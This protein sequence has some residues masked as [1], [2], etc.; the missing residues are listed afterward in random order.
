MNIFCV[1]QNY[2]VQKGEQI[3]FAPVPVIFVKP[4]NALLPSGASF[5]CPNFA[6]VLYCGSELVLRIS[7][8]GKDV[9]EADAG[10]YYDSITIGINF[11]AI[12]KLD[13]LNGDASSW[14][15]A[16]AWKNSSIAGEW[17]P[18]TNFKN[19]K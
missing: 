7:K 15:K 2:F 9:N 3:D 10:K 13:A 19:K 5:S 1:E 18:A 6:N 11:T 8:G 17:I 14:Q 12:D 4:P 16:K